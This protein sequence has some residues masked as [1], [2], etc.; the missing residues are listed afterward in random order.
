M[1][2]MLAMGAKS[3][4]KVVAELL[5]ERRVDG[6]SRSCHQQRVAVGGRTRDRL[7]ADVVSGAGP[8]LDHE[9]LTEAFRQPLADQAR[10]E[11]DRSARGDGHDDAHG[12]RRIGLRPHNAW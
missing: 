2:L 3:R 9:R 12:P 10:P 8:V 5:E 7:G 6:G 11:V 1:W 4:R